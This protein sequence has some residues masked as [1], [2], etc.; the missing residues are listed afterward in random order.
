MLFLS[1]CETFDLNQTQD[2]NAIALENL[3]YE[4][5]FNYVQLQLPVSLTVLILLLKELLVKWR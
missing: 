4:L 1:S 5:A 3:E 2:P